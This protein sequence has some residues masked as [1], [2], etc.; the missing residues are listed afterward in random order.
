MRSKIKQRITE[1]DEEKAKRNDERNNPIQQKRKN[2]QHNLPRRRKSSKPLQRPR[3]PRQKN[4]RSRNNLLATKQHKRRRTNNK[5]HRQQRTKNNKNLRPKNRL[6]NANQNP[7]TT[8]T[9]NHP[10]TTKQ[11]HRKKNP[12]TTKQNLS[13]TYD[14]LGNIQSKTNQITKKTETYTYDNLN[15][16]TKAQG[17]QTQT[18]RYN[19][20]GNITYKSNTGTYYYGQNA[21]A[22]AVTTIKTPSGALTYSYDANGNQ[23]AQYTNRKQT[24]SISYTSFGKPLQITTANAQTTYHYNANRKRFEK[25]NQQGTKTTTTYFMGNYEQE[26]TTT[27]TQTTTTQKYYLAPNTL[28]TKTTTN[29]QTITNTYNLLTN[30]QGSITAI[31]NKNC[32]TLQ[33]YSYTP[34]GEQTQTKGQTTPITNKGYTGHEEIKSQ[35]LIHMNGRLYDPTIGRFLSADPTIQHPTN[36]QNLNRYSYCGNNPI[37]YTDPTGYNWWHHLWHS[38]GHITSRNNSYRTTDGLGSWSK[39]PRPKRRRANRLR[40][41]QQTNSQQD[42]RIGAWINAI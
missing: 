26:T 7:N 14:A 3:I 29:G 10:K 2:T 32:Q 8:T 22:Q 4:K 13:Y 39:I 16:L 42:T 19:A 27:P 9:T 21:G 35:N 20:M 33:K 34:Y 24:R 36:T 31:T 6:P 5:L 11:T 41:K 1:R 38:V 37:N 23:T 15:R 28:Y 18:Y 17:E 30:N 12:I 40:T 25:T